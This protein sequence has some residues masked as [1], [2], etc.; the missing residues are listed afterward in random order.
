[1]QEAM[2]GS[3]DNAAGKF[4]RYS[5]RQWGIGHNLLSFCMFRLTTGIAV[6]VSQA[7]WHSH[8]G[9]AESDEFW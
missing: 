2:S 8:V 1:M 4:Q 7:V 3:V 9:Q 5:L 6:N